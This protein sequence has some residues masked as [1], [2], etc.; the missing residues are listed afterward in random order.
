MFQ[1]LFLDFQKFEGGNAC[2]MKG[3]LKYKCHTYKVHF[4][5][6]L[7]PN[8]KLA[9]FVPYLKI[10]TPFWKMIYESYS[11]LTKKVKNGIKI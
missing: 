6:V 4:K 10:K 8:L 9:C 7:H 5:V 3:Y 11:K 1:T 2:D